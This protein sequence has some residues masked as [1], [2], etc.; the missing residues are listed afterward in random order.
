MGH[1]ARDEYG[2]I[3]TILPRYY[4]RGADSVAHRGVCVHD[5]GEATQNR[6]VYYGRRS[7]AAVDPC[8][9]LMLEVLIDAMGLVTGAIVPAG[10][11]K[12]RDIED[13]RRWMLNDDVDYTF[14]FVTICE[15]LG[16]NPQQVRKAVFNG[17]FDWSRRGAHSLRGSKR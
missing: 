17:Q 3:S 11:H 16:F 15:H 10:K 8:S 12:C 14:S 5:N 9:R 6:E 13:A 4:D 1:P 2:P 7:Q